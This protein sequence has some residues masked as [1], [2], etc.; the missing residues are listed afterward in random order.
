MQCSSM[1]ITY[2][3]QIACQD[4]TLPS[5]AVYTRERAHRDTLVTLRQGMLG[6]KGNTGTLAVNRS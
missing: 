5:E 4:R 3:L 2:K 6:N 1:S